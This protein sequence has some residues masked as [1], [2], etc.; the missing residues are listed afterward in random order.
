MQTTETF[1]VYQAKGRQVFL[2]FLDILLVLLSLFVI[3]LGWLDKS[4]MY[5]L[6]GGCG[7]VLFVVCGGFLVRQFVGGKVLV[8][9]TAEGFYDYSSLAASGQLIRWE[10][11]VDIQETAFGGQ[12]FISVKLDNEADYLSHLSAYKRR[13]GQAN[14]KLTGTP[15]N[16]TLNTARFMT[17][18]ELLEQMTAY[19]KQAGFPAEKD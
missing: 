2:L 16:L 14:G 8:Y 3:Y 17:S 4:F 18:G 6:V 12:T 10:D 13:L 7:T 5:Y 1:T 19:W 11:V 15:V 9:L